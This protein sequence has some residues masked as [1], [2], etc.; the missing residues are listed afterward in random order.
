MGLVG[1]VVP[2]PPHQAC[3]PRAGAGAGAGRAAGAA[4]VGLQGLNVFSAD[5]KTEVLMPNCGRGRTD[6]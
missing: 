4:P 6:S 3:W 1:K 2:P 5:M